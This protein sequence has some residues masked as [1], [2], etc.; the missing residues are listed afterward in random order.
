M[1]YAEILRRAA[2]VPAWVGRGP[3]DHSFGSLICLD[4][5][6]ER[7]LP[8]FLHF[9]LL[10]HVKTHLQTRPRH[11]V[12]YWCWD[13]CRLEQTLV[14]RWDGGPLPDLQ[15]QSIPSPQGGL[16]MIQ[17]A[18]LDE[19]VLAVC[20]LHYQWWIISPEHPNCLVCGGPPTHS[21][22]LPLYGEASAAPFSLAVD[23]EAPPEPPILIAVKCPHCDNDVTL[24]I[25]EN[26]ISVVPPLSP[27]VTEEAAPRNLTDEGPASS[28]PAEPASGAEVEPEH[29]VASSGAAPS[30]PDA[31][32]QELAS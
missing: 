15:A 16:D 23:V 29:E 10:V 2:G 32:P 11:R 28:P 22:T 24:E 3:P 5:P 14:P 9:P 6:R 7:L 8:S 19:A 13:C 27:Q 25:G 26:G 17:P 1:R 31:E 12:A 30:A 4:C 20:I 18:P 21:L